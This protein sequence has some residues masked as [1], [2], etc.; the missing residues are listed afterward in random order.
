MMKKKTNI[1]KLFIIFICFV[2]VIAGISGL[3][4]PSQKQP[5]KQEEV[6]VTPPEYLIIQDRVMMF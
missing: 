3:T 6:N 2:F 5:E 4:G 1:F